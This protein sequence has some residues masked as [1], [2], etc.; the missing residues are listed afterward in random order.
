[1]SVICYSGTVIQMMLTPTRT[2]THLTGTAKYPSKVQAS[3]FCRDD[4]GDIHLTLPSPSPFAFH[5][6]PSY[7]QL[8]SKLLPP[9]SQGRAPQ[10]SGRHDI[11]SKR[12]LWT[13]V[14]KPYLH[15]YTQDRHRHTRGHTAKPS[16]TPTFADLFA[17]ASLDPVSYAPYQHVAEF[18]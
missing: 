17:V 4:R 5:L 16:N 7:M 9:R 12:R 14:S 15:M 8:P 3:F 13:P 18:L 11:I 1:M 10:V 2:L 6:P